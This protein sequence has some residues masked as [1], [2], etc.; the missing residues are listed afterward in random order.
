M[1]CNPTT[2]L[3]FVAALVLLGGA[4]P[5]SGAILNGL[6]VNGLLCCTGNGNCPGQRL[7]NVGVRLNCTVLGLS[8]TVVGIGTTNATGGYTITIPA[9]PGLL[10]GSP[11]L[12]CNVNIKL[13]LDAAVCPVLSATTGFLVGT[14][15]VVGTVFNTVLGLVQ[16]ASVDAYVHVGA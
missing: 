7:A 16:V 12:P 13:P 5:S 6:T 14:L 15:H 4:S 3:L 9:L 11:L 1:A 2:L 10:L 8:S